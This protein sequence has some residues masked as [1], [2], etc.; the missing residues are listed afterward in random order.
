MTEVDDRQHSG[1]V[2]EPLD[3]VVK[4]EVCPSPV[5]QLEEFLDHLDQG[6][7]Y[8]DH[9]YSPEIC[10][11]TDE[12]VVTGGV[13]MGQSAGVVL[14]FGGLL[15]VEVVGGRGLD[16]ISREEDYEGDVEG[17]VRVVDI[18][19]ETVPFVLD[20]GQDQLVTQQG[21][22]LRSRLEICVAAIVNL[23]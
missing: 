8:Y 7:D 21:H 23:S 9:F 11:L 17:Q 14:D 19:T 6:H 2:D 13:E 16:D 10:L 5:S 3:E 15:V 18:A 22:S 1:D 4:R 12:D 20:Q